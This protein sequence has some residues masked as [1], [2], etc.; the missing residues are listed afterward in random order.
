[1]LATALSLR[2]LIKSVTRSPWFQHHL[3]TSPSALTP[4]LLP[5]SG[6]QLAGRAWL[7]SLPPVSH[8][9]TYLK[10]R[11]DHV[12]SCLSPFSS[13]PH[14]QDNVQSASQIL[15]GTVWSGSCSSLSMG[16]PLT[17]LWPHWAMCVTLDV[18][19]SPARR[20]TGRMVPAEG[21]NT[22]SPLQ[23]G[24]S[25]PFST[26]FSLLSPQV[27]WLLLLCHYSLDRPLAQYS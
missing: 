16:H 13:S 23:H 8:L 7:L 18:P 2:P 6:L 4:L 21:A 15:S 11:H 19:T 17:R 25:I 24:S 3:W 22:S 5:F 12:I 10:H 26:D 9:L 1:M 14:F 20:Q 27:E